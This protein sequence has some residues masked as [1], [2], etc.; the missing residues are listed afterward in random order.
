[1][2]DK[3]YS[4]HEM[5]SLK[6]SL[7]KYFEE[8]IDYEHDPTPVVRGVNLENTVQDSMQGRSPSNPYC[9][10]SD[11]IAGVCRLDHYNQKGRNTPLS[12]N[13]MY[14]ILQCMEIIN[15]REIKKMMGV[16]D[17]QARV[18]V[19]ACRVA[20]PFLEHYFEEHGDFLEAP[21]FL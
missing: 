8:R 20:L 13:R 21:D 11:I 5:K 9:G 16:G 1:M 14:N 6:K 10:V 15:T 7:G 2:E 3:T 17:R 12:Q 18:Y 4:I 19:R